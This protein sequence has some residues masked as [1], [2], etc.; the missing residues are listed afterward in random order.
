M[1]FESYAGLIEMVFVYSIALG[2][3]IWQVVKMRRQ[4]AADRSAREQR[5]DAQSCDKKS[6]K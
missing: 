2:I 6:D 3:G 4:I 1:S 5:I